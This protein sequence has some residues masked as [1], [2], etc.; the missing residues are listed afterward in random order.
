MLLWM[1]GRSANHV[2]AILLSGVI[3]S[4]GSNVSWD[5]HLCGA[6]AGVIVGIATSEKANGVF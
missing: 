5:G 6:I 2:G 4:F 1:F 3:P